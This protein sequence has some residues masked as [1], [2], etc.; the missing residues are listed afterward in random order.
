MATTRT[1]VLAAVVTVGCA[2]REIEVTVEGG[3]DTPPTFAWDDGPVD[4]L[5]VW[6]C[7]SDC[8]QVQCGRVVPFEGGSVAVWNYGDSAYD[9]IPP[10]VASPVAYGATGDP[11][12][13]A[14][15]EVLFPGAM[16]AVELE[17]LGTCNKRGVCTI[18]ASGCAVFQP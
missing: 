4:V 11:D 5:T 14:E 6:R 9:E 10:A 2:S 8:D 12:A 7:Q 3:G 16:Y 15:A 13:D 18:L 17:R 1:L